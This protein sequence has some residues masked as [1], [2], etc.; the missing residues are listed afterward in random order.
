MKTCYSYKRVSSKE[1]QEKRNSIPEQDRRIKEFASKNNIK[2]LRDFEDSNSAFHDENR[3]NFE[4]MINLALKER[5]NYIILDDSSR[6]A[7]TRQIAID[8]KKKL[9]SYGINILYASE[10]N[11]DI[12]TVA[13]FWLEGIQEIK[14]EATSREIAFHVKKGMSGNLFQRDSNTGWC[15]KNGGK[16]PYG[17]KRNVLYCGISKKGK[18]VYKTIWELNEDTYHIVKKI[19]V[20]MYTEKEMS[21]TQI[22]DYLNNNNIMNSN[23]GV[24]STSTIVSMLREDRLEE[25][26]GVAIWNK[27]N[28]NVIGEK[29]NS[30]DEWVICDNAHPA[31]ITKEEL[32]KALERKSK[33]NNSNYK[34]KPNSDYLLSG[35]NI[36]N[37]FLFICSECGGH[38]IG[39][40]TG[41]KRDKKY[42]CANNRHK[43]TC[44]CYNNWKIE[45]EWV[46]NTVINIIESNYLA[47]KKLDTTIDNVYYE[48]CNISST[49]DKEIKNLNNEYSKIDNQI[50]NLL[51]S[52]KVGLDT[53]IAVE[54]IN[55]LKEQKDSIAEKISNLEL[56]KNEKPNI[57]KNDIREYFYNLKKL[58]VVAD[59]NEKR[60]LIKTFVSNIIL[61]KKEHH[62]E[63]ILYSQW[64]PLL[65][66]VEGIEPSSSAWKAEVIAIIRHLHFFIFSVP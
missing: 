57:N 62:I 27:E 26:A 3:T 35:M 36:E 42:C 44:S 29:Y 53:S 8:T 52:I 18:P 66:Q 9:R 7:R 28:K 63:V 54:E 48:I 6:F 51:N 58:F 39:S 16:A 10:P 15:Y 61:N 31:I 22:R 59:T 40:S 49:Y 56:K 60:E 24:W 30:R 46:E 34:F 20:E 1:Q 55:K 33:T 14:N 45:K 19:I 41:K 47:D 11:I 13:G 21:Y 37:N 64:C 43:G 4:K 2:I 25:Y 50:Q 65:E 32:Q 12:N 23:G 38:I 5:P 17:Y